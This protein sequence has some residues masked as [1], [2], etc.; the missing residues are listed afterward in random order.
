MPSALLSYGAGYGV[1]AIL[2]F[3]FNVLPDPDAYYRTTALVRLHI[4]NWYSSGT[5]SLSGSFF[6]PRI[7]A[8]KQI[9]L[10][11]VLWHAVSPVEFLVVLA[12][13]GALLVRRSEADRLLAIV[14]GGVLAASAVILL[15]ASALYYIHVMP[16]LAIPVAPL[17]THGLKR[18][19]T[20]ARERNAGF[21]SWIAFA[22]IAS[23]MCASSSAKLARKLHP[24]PD[25][26]A[27]DLAFAREARAATSPQCV[28]AGDAG[29]YIRYFPD[30]PHF[31]SARPAEV[32]IAM[33]YYGVEDE[34]AFWEIKSPT[35]IFWPG[36]LSDGLAGY[37]TKHGM[38]RAADGVWVDAGRC[39]PAK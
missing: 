39:G 14:I 36:Q 27:T 10:Y 11:R 21:G 15:H 5:T 34:A 38:T 31:I 29:L 33:L 19:S 28:V 23:F 25:N 16:A 17:L 2:Y 9:E 24:T 20:T 8:S 3:C 1:G 7:L 32:A 35:A 12:G 30:Y 18:E 4:T 6:D 37:A 26:Q 22:L 13:I